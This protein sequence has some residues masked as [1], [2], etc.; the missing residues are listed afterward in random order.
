[1]ENFSYERIC[2]VVLLYYLYIVHHAQLF[3]KKAYDYT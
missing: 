1:M 2:Y 3:K